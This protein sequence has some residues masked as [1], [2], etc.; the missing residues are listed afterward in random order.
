MD[1][2]EEAAPEP[3]RQS[4]RTTKGVG[5]DRLTYGTP[6]GRGRGTPAG[7]AA[8]TQPVGPVSIASSK[9]T[10]S[11][12]LL[13]VELQKRKKLAAIESAHR[14]AEKAVRE[15]ELAAQKDLVE[16]EAEVDRAVILEEEDQNLGSEDDSGDSR[17]QGGNDN[18]VVQE[19]VNQGDH[20]ER[21]ALHQFVHQPNHPMD[22]S[23]Q[24]IAAT[25][26]KLAAVTLA[27]NETK[28]KQ[29]GG[30][31]FQARKLNKE[32]N[33]F[34]GDPTNWPM[35]IAEFERTTKSCGF[36]PEENL[37]RL[38]KCLKGKALH[39]VRELLT[40]ADNVKEIISTL[41]EQFGRPQLI[42]KTLIEKARKVP[43]LKDGKPEAVVEFSNVVRSVVAEMKNSKNEG[44]LKNPQLLEEFVEKLSPQLWQLWAEAPKE[45]DEEPDLSTF[46]L[47]LKA[48]A[49]NMLKISSSRP[50]GVF[51]R[52]TENKDRVKSSRTLTASEE[53]SEVEKSSRT[54]ATTEERYDSGGSNKKKPPAKCPCCM[55]AVHHLSSCKDFL[56]KDTDDRWTI[57][58]KAH[59]CFSCL[60][61][62][63]GW[64]TCEEDKECGRDE[65]TKSHH[66]LL[67]KERD[68]S[69]SPETVDV[70]VQLAASGSNVILGMVPVTLV[71]PRGEFHTY[72]LMDPGASA[73]LVDD[74][75]ANKIGLTGPKK[76]LKMNGVGKPTF[77]NT[78]RVVEVGIRGADQWRTYTESGVRTVKNLDLGLQCV[79]VKGVSEQYPHLK[80][81]ERVSPMAKVRP[82]I[83]IGE[84][85]GHLFDVRRPMKG[86]TVTQTR[87]GWMVH[88]TLEEAGKR[89]P[90]VRVFFTDVRENNSS[91][92]SQHEVPGSNATAQK[93]LVELKKLRRVNLVNPLKL[94][95]EDDESTEHQID[96]DSCPDQ[97]RMNTDTSIYDGEACVADK[98]EK[99]N[100]SI[101]HMKEVPSLASGE[102]RTEGMM[103]SVKTVVF[104]VKLI[105]GRRCAPTNTHSWESWRALVIQ[106]LGGGVLWRSK[107]EEGGLMVIG[108]LTRKLFPLESCE[109]DKTKDD[110]KPGR[111]VL[112]EWRRRMT[113]GQVLQAL[114]DDGHVTCQ[115]R[116]KVY[117]TGQ[118][119]IRELDPE[120]IQAAFS[121]KG[122]ECYF[123]PPS[124]P[125]M[126]GCWE[127]LMQSVKKAL[128]TTLKELVPRKEVL[129]TLLVEAENIV[130]SRP[131]THVS[132]DPDDPESLTRNHFLIGSSNGSAA[133][134]TFAEMDLCLRKQ[135]RIAQ[136]LVD[137]FWKRWVHE[138]LPT[139]TRRTNWFRKTGPVKVGDLVFIADGNLP[140]NQWPRGLVVG[141]TLGPDGQV[142]VAE[143]KTQFGLLTRH[144]VKLCVL[145]VE[146]KDV[147]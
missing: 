140:R 133:P 52:E 104:I 90:E 131:L 71:G 31:K 36:V 18:G 22:P 13:Q 51:S 95:L 70:N 10:T 75:V 47:W 130:N 67:H 143:V 142:R 94:I 55:K 25:L 91:E 4:A 126:G 5:P 128:K 43:A 60:S 24:L 108:S 50:V 45:G 82:M 69:E 109:G 118:N 106:C 48:R 42:I 123:I 132:V 117:D 93:S 114:P 26:E 138:Y 8:R 87:L 58:K 76:T 63:H 53:R 66:P 44:Y 105:A 85:K 9:S 110:S 81:I 72:A 112:I 1:D 27:K 61:G 80:N 41:K 62:G 77:D 2:H 135:W 29:E 116:G 15:A 23:M 16:L 147:D 86:P 12:K 89:S 6:I 78:S 99:A 129:Q 64:S 30:D 83:L 113:D 103:E 35:F 146:K 107:P 127:R 121:G 101:P 92:N 56:S 19:W 32:L 39:A 38:Q 34:H 33:Q 11:R 124:A 3:T 98:M 96:S 40:H 144:V 100:Y 28:V 120:R 49:S 57:A 14:E 137:Q 54:L 102:E 79:D 65:C 17:R 74:G 136:R 115:S 111:A 88:G 84:D 7:N 139:L 145:D 73:T 68:R 141:T 119:A 20:E 122:L 59:L 21:E 134:G 125:H 97:L 37:A 46:S